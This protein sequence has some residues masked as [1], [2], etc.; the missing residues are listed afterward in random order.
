MSGLVQSATG[1][2]E[3][4][5]LEDEVNRLA[6]HVD[7]HRVE[8]H[9]VGL[10]EVLDDPI[11]EP[12]ALVFTSCPLLGLASLDA[13]LNLEDLL[14]GEL[15]LDGDEE[16]GAGVVGVDPVRKYEQTTATLLDEVQQGPGLGHALP[17]LSVEGPDDEGAVGVAHGGHGPIQLWALVVLQVGGRGPHLLGVDLDDF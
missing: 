10:A 13:L 6:D 1:V 15:R 3:A 2:T 16:S 8:G 5:A 11:G 7:R 9:V 14:T 12:P 4:L 17:G